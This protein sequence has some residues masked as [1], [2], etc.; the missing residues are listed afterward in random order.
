MQPIVTPPPLPLAVPEFDGR[1]LG[2]PGIEATF[3][4]EP[5]GSGEPVLL[6]HV[7]PEA[8]IDQ[9]PQRVRL[10][11]TSDEARL[12]LWVERQSLEPTIDAAAELLDPHG[13]HGDGTHG[14]WLA[15]GTRIVVGLPE[16]HTLLRTIALPPTELAASGKV[17]KIEIGEVFTGPPPDAK[18]TGEDQDVAAQTPIYAAPAAT[19]RLLATTAHGVSARRLGVVDGWAEIELNHAGVRVRGF[20]NAPAVGARRAPARDL[21]ASAGSS[22]TISETDKITVPAGTC[23]YDRDDGT[24]IGV[25]LATQVRFGYHRTD[26]PFS[27]VYVGT[28]HWDHARLAIRR[29]GDS[30]ESCVAK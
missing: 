6:E 29:A 9:T 22:F 1:R 7:E 23:L 15:V 12:A 17:Y 26:Q 10:V 18:V 8:V 25:T 19:S 16:E 14:I 2:N 30:W 11:E 4:G 5:F 3:T 21:V 13:E 27:S 20:V 28:R 24:V